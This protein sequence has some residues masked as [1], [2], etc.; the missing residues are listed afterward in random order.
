MSRFEYDPEDAELM[1][2][3][4]SVDLSTLLTGMNPKVASR[5]SAHLQSIGYPSSGL[6]ESS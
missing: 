1:P 6:Q 4:L 2:Q 3:P 5:F